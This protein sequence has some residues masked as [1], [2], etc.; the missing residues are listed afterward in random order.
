VSW[1]G[2]ADRR[3]S[4]EELVGLLDREASEKWLENLDQ[5][6]PFNNSFTPSCPIREF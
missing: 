2:S 6:P 3:W 1:E 4:F 5:P